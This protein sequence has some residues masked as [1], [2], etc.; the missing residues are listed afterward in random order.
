VAKAFVFAE[1]P[2]SERDE[3]SVWRKDSDEDGIGEITSGR[4]TV[5]FVDVSVVV[6]MKGRGRGKRPGA[7][8]VRIVCEGGSLRAFATKVGK[9]VEGGG[10][11]DRG[12]RQGS[13]SR[14]RQDD[15]IVQIGNKVVGEEQRR[16]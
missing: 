3:G 14:A 12:R 10:G 2:R 1:E 9:G 16:S 11:G 8:Q 5:N 4:D 13:K 6:S 7:D 15:D